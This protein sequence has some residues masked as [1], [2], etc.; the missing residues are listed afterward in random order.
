M[1]IPVKTWKYSNFSRVF[2][3]VGIVPDPDLTLEK[4]PDPDQTFKKKLN[5][6]T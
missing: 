5:K 2:D 4:E 3:P 1:N 6:Q